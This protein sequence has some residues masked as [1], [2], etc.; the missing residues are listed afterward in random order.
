MP[1]FDDYKQ[2][3][4]QPARP[5]GPG[6]PMD[7]AIRHDCAHEYEPDEAAHPGDHGWAEPDVR[8]KREPVLVADLPLP[9]PKDHPLTGDKPTPPH[10]RYD[11]QNCL[12]GTIAFREEPNGR[13]RW[14]HKHEGCPFIAALKLRRYPKQRSA[15]DPKPRPHRNRLLPKLLKLYQFQKLLQAGAWLVLCYYDE[16]TGQKKPKYPNCYGCAP[17]SSTSCTTWRGMTTA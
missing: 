14:K 6:R 2:A 12:C 1:T 10:R 9:D 11:H 15:Y 16:L 4:S 13:I 17:S 3:K 7:G 5:A 8:P